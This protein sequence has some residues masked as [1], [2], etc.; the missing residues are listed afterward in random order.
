M[1]KFSKDSNMRKLILLILL[2]LFMN[3][4]YSKELVMENQ[5]DAFNEFAIQLVQDEKNPTFN[6]EFLKPK[7]LDYS[8]ESLN[9]I[10]KFLID[11]DKKELHLMPY[12][13]IVR[14][15]LRTGAYV[16]ETVRK[17]DKNI[18]WNW[19][20]Y[21]EAIKLH[22]EI[23]Q[24]QEKSLG[25]RFLLIGTNKKDSIVHFSFPINKVLKNLENGDEDSVYAFAITQVKLQDEMQNLEMD[26]NNLK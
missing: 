8:L 5:N 23:S 17:N 12:E 19:V 16:G 18:E 6:R 7:Q 2:V 11:A 26:S 21:D 22:P 15:A 1:K 25:T 20:E 14:L 13:D 10:N 24:Y 4:S 3:N 9:F